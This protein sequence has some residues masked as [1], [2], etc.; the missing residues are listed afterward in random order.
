MFERFGLA[1][2]FERVTLNIFDEIN[3]VVPKAF[4]S[5]VA[6]YVNTNKRGGP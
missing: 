4:V 1:D 3:C 2:S 5:E 6:Q